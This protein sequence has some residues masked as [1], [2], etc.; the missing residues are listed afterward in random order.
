MI[1]IMDTFC[2]HAGE[3]CGGGDR[4]RRHNLIRNI[5]YYG[6]SA[7]GLQPELERPGLL[8][9]RPCQG[10]G[11]EDGSRRGNNDDDPTFR[12]PADV[13][14]PRWRSGPPAAWDFAVTSG[15]RSDVI[16]RS[17]SDREAALTLYEDFKCSYKDTK[18]QCQEA[19]I[20]FVL[21]ILESVGGGWGKE[22]RRIW[23]ELAKA[24]ALASGELQSESESAISL[25]QR[26]SI[27]LHRENARAILRRR[28]PGADLSLSGPGVALAATL[29]EDAAE[30]EA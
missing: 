6:A 8:P 24:S 12:R 9:A 11:Y 10:G 23:T 28:A 4:T 27:T 3:C 22:A 29:A 5:T 25:L 20:T 19:G 14:I 17:A 1:Q 13:Y 26:L 18:R 21:L 16:T 2:D 7:A 15:V 30:R